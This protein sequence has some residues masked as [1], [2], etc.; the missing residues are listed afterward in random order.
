M[1]LTLQL[2]FNEKDR[3][4]IGRLMGL[5]IATT[6]DV[7]EWIEQNLETSLQTAYEIAAEVDAGG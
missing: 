4:A 2:Q 1:T 7:R 5:D 6:S 3:R